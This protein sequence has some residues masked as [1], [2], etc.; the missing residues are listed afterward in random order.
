MILGKMWKVSYCFCTEYKISSLPATVPVESVGLVV[1]PM[2]SDAVPQVIENNPLPRLPY[3][4]CQG[5]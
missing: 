1:I 3:K 2:L 5:I 4:I